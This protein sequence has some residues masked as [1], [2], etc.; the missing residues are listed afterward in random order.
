MGNENLDA[1]IDALYRIK[2]GLAAY[3]SYLA[4]CEMNA[5]F[6]EHIL[7]EPVLRNSYRNG[8]RFTSLDL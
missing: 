4:A 2:R 3:V 8:V 1:T 5:A 6:S 7:H